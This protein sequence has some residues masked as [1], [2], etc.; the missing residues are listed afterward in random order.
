MD[1]D[2]EPDIDCIE[3]GLFL[4]SLT[5]ASNLTTLTNYN[6][7]HI[8]TVD[9][10]CLPVHIN[11]QSEFRT[12]FIQADDRPHADLLSHFEEANEFIEDGIKNGAVLVHW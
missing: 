9:V 12:L 10:E 1:L 11:E 5:A 6:I 8:L 2:L 3:P 7:T 4:G